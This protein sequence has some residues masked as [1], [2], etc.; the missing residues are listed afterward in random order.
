MAKTA[1]QNLLI[2]YVRMPEPGQVKTRLAADV[3]DEA[4]CELY[5]AFTDAA[6]ARGRA[7]PDTTLR[8]DYA[9]DTAAACAYFAGRYP[10]APLAPQLDGGLGARM[11][12]SICSGLSAGHTRVCLMGSDIPDMPLRNLHAAFQYLGAHQAV[13]M[14]TADGGYCLVGARMPTPEIFD[15]TRIPWS[16]PQVLQATVDIAARS[17]IPLAMA[18]Q[19]H[20]VDNAA[21]LAALRLRI[22]KLPNSDIITPLRR[23]LAQWAP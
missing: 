15:D 2:V 6:I 23:A 16:T 3:G 11:H 19:W 18:P 22:R 13:I 7:V 10:G 1:T 8:L 14:P 9:P 20:D 17:R 12:A 5:R 21:D 4:A